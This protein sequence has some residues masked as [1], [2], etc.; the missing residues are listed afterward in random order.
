M[1]I[2]IFVELLATSANITRIQ[3]KVAFHA[4]CFNLGFME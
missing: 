3:P 2:V 4:S 1:L